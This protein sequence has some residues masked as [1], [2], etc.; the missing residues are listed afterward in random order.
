NPALLAGSPYRFDLHLGGLSGQIQNNYVGLRSSAILNGNWRTISDSNYTD[1][2]PR[3]LNGESKSL[4][5]Q[6]EVQ[7]P[8][9]LVSLNPRHAVA[10]T[11]RWRTLGSLNRLGE[12]AARFAYEGLEVPDQ[13]GTTYNNDGF[14]LAAASFLEV[15]L[16]YAGQVYQNG[17]HQLQA[18]L[19]LRWLRSLAG[20][21]FY[22]RRLAYSFDDA[23][24]LN[25][26]EG[27]IE[28][29]HSAAIGAIDPN[30]QP[31][32]DLIGQE[33]CSGLGVDL[34][35]S[36]T[37]A[38]ADDTASGRPYRLRMG[39][40][41]LDMGRVSFN[42][43]ASTGTFSGSVTGYNLNTLN[44]GNSVAFF[45]S[46]LQAE[47]S[48]TPGANTFG[49]ALPTTLSIQ[50]D[51]YLRPR[52][53]VN[54]SSALAFQRIDCADCLRAAT[55]VTLTPRIEGRRRSLGIPLSVTGSNS[56]G[57]G[58]MAQLGP[59]VV[60]SGNLASAL[61]TD[62]LKALDAFV[63]VRVPLGYPT[64]KDRDRDGV[65][66]KED[67]CPREPGLASNQG[68][69]EEEEPAEV[70]AALP[71]PDPQAE[72]PT[73][74]EPEPEPETQPETPPQPQPEPQPAAQPEAPAPQVQPEPAPQPEPQI[75]AP[76]PQP[77]PEPEPQ[78]ASTP[79]TPPQVAQGPQE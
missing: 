9:L 64:Q 70:V 44:G 28:Y 36:Y 35:A 46:T 72:V 26:E 24:T 4:T 12:P 34:G 53:A 17:P 11:S 21:Y 7:L 37:Y 41:L 5:F 69:P 30:F 39:L 38:T 13:F 65:P 77:Q 32:R 76:A 59:V 33:G 66:D 40:S 50:G 56:F 61:V 31:T 48:Y 29:A 79:A 14:G 42:Q 22:A 74:P 54:L 58:V 71:E 18:G 62:N 49:M 3:V 16:A 52:L 60:G 75:P 68:C 20:S 57:M 1:I 2:L 78:V 15:G 63:A 23:E 19:H 55:Y 6:T 45:D 10:L 51:L 8:S 67:A 27:E 73:Q 43:S 47:F 25:I